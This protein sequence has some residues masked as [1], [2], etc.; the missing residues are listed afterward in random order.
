MHLTRYASIQTT[1]SLCI[2]DSIFY[3]YLVLLSNKVKTYLKM[4]LNDFYHFILFV[5]FN[6]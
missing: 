4:C 1:R 2:D 5:Y 3:S 6:F